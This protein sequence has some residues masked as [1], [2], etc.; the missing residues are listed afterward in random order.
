MSTLLHTTVAK[1]T[2]DLYK[3]QMVWTLGYLAIIT[4][5]NV[6]LLQFVS[7]TKET[8]SLLFHSLSDASRIYMAIIG[9]II[10]YY[11]L[12]YMVGI[13]ITRRQY[14][15]STALSALGISIS[16]I[17]LGTA[18][19]ALLSLTGLQ[20]GPAVAAGM[21][22]SMVSAI[23]VLFV[24]YLAGWFVT[25][26]FYRFGTLIGIGFLFVGILY[27]AVTQLIWQMRASFPLGPISLSTPSL[28]FASSA[29]GTLLL[30]VLGLAVIRR[31]TRR[32]P[33]RL[34]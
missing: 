16:I 18:V 21:P 10:C 12:T 17:V 13:G 32:I 20:A 29:T 14:M 6:L 27:A 3:M 15:A 25:L 11:M 33:V 8:E 22:R 2:A 23:L 34:D 30:V 7:S 4:M 24:Y 28:S 9:S 5:I 31:I 19:S 26:G 1:A